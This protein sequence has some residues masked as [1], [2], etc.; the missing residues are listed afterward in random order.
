MNI[1][2]TVPYN[3]VQETRKRKIIKNYKISYHL[4]Y[5]CSCLRKALVTARHDFCMVS[6][7]NHVQWSISR[8]AKCEGKWKLHCMAVLWIRRIRGMLVGSTVLSTSEN[9]M[10]NIWDSKDIFILSIQTWTQRP[11]WHSKGRK[12]IYTGGNIAFQKLKN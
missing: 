5:N 2:F 1:W 11:N 6:V 3:S 7:F 9:C 12:R 10:V 8:G 4:K